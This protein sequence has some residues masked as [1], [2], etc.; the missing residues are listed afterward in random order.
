MS[1][2]VIVRIVHT[3]VWAFFVACILAIWIFAWQGA[4]FPA[5]LSIGIVSL[6]VL[7]LA[8]NGWRCPLTPIAA[9]YTE[10]RRDNFDIYLP[11]WL[12]RHNKAIFGA[13]YVGGILFTLVLWIVPAGAGR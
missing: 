3:V 13:L 9:R 8:A 1:A 6:E 12:A 5:L 4:W 11:A 10:E 7:V 2:L